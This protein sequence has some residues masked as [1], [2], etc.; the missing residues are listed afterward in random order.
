[1][2]SIHIMQILVWGILLLAPVWPSKLPCYPENELKEKAYRKLRTHYLQPPEPAHV[3]HAD[4]P[5]SCP[6]DR[7]QHLVH[8]SDRSLS[9]WRYVYETQED[10]FP[11][12]FAV[13]QCLCTGCIV[14]RDGKVQEEN[15]AYNSDLIMQ[16]RLFLMKEM[17]E[18]GQT[19]RLV[20]KNENI[21]VACTCARPKYTS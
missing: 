5:V 2:D 20:P 4:S 9:P 19:Y 21:G 3:S 17:C 13:A 16:S 8:V 15:L 1:M 7:Y 18:D 11:S 10:R 12:T 6:V 14:M